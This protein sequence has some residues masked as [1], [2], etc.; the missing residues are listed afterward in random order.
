MRNGQAGRGVGRHERGLARGAP[1][2]S[3]V[4]CIARTWTLMGGPDLS[5]RLCGYNQIAHPCSGSEA[6]AAKTVGGD[7]TEQL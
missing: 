4:Y 7:P 3:G 6:G 1:S 5:V 2:A